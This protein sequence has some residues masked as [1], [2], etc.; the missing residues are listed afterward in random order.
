M[1]VVGTFAVGAVL[2]DRGGGPRRNAARALAA[3]FVVATAAYAVAFWLEHAASERPD[4]D[5]VAVGFSSSAACWAAT[6]AVMALWGLADAAVQSYAYW[7]L[8]ALYADR[9]ADKARAV[10]F[11]KMVQSAGFC[12]GFALLPPSRCSYEKQL[13]L[14][15]ATFVVGVALA[16]FELPPA[17]IATDA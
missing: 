15:A 14:C 2:D 13:S 4:D 3:F 16:I 9:E 1:E 17:V 10:A 7:V 12:V 11:Y 5:P 6:T 8:G